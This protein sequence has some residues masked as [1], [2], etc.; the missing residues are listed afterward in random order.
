MPAV[1][2][3]RLV[4]RCL[5][6]FDSIVYVARRS[7]PDSTVFACSPL[8]WLS[9]RR[10]CEPRPSQRSPHPGLHSGVV[11]TQRNGCCPSS[12][13]TRHHS[14]SSS[15]RPTPLKHLPSRPLPQTRLLF[16][17]SLW[18]LLPTGSVELSGRILARHLRVSQQPLRLTVLLQLHLQLLH[19]ML[20]SLRAAQRRIQK[21][22]LCH[23]GHRHLQRS[24]DPA[25]VTQSM[26]RMLCSSWMRMRCPFAPACCLLSGVM[27][28]ATGSCWPPSD[29][30]HASGLHSRRRRPQSRALVCCHHVVC[31]SDTAAA[32]RPLIFGRND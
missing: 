17:P 4:N 12:S 9:S 5:G 30:F 27:K 1:G 8:I 21:R 11:T 6:G 25:I 23:L 31:C 3:D 7:S 26:P 22:S 15:S 29:L 13:A 16:R 18:L 10:P 14:R 28:S 24:E 2:P 20:L 32:S 19:Q